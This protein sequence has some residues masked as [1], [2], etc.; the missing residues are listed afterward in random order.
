MA[1]QMHY[2]KSTKRP[3]HTNVV[4]NVCDLC[5]SEQVSIICAD[6]DTLLNK[7]TELISKCRNRYKFLLANV[8]KG[9]LM[10]I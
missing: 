9:T 3:H 1:M 4:P 6:P 8:V 10:Q 5:L 7:T 2:G